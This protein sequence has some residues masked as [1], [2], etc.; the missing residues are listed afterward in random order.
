MKA[1][2]TFI[3]AVLFTTLIT[4][5]NPTNAYARL[6]SWKDTTVVQPGNGG[7]ASNA[8]AIAGAGAGLLT[9]A[10]AVITSGDDGGAGVFAL[11]IIAGIVAIIS[12]TTGLVN[13]RNWKKRGKAF[14]DR[15]QSD[16]IRSKSVLGIVLGILAT[17]V[18]IIILLLKSGVMGFV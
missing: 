9:I 16:S 5:L 17:G 14:K 13:S 18:S 12:G 3:S 4:F 11:G 8:A 7:K 15:Y 6:D 2:L 1:N 10:T